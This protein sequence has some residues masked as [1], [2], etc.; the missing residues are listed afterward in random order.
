MPSHRL[1]AP[2][3]VDDPLGRALDVA[4]TGDR[5][6]LYAF[7]ARHSGLPCAPAV[8]ANPTLVLAFASHVVARGK[9][10]DALTREMATLDADRAP[11][12][13]PLEF[14]PMCGVAAVGARAASDVSNAPLFKR[15]M[16]VLEVA[17]EDL[18]FR[19][20]D[21]VPRALVRIGERRGE[22]FVAELAGWMDG[23]FQAAAVLAALTDTTWL[24]TI[25]HHEEIILRLDEA[26]EL[27]R[28]AD[29]ARERYPGYKALVD[30]LGTTPGMIA[31]RFGPP[32]FD[33][34]VAWSTVKEPLLREAIRSS[35]GGSLLG[36]RFAGDIARVR[37][38]LDASAP[39]RR[40]PRT[41]VGSTRGRGRKKQR[42]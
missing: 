38:A 42:R 36:K 2:P 33:R 17:A 40:D 13:T 37:S 35:L 25:R 20:R 18:R 11:G 24:S 23:F 1:P 8:R 32:V 22:A 27:A 10:C 12:G 21:E 5:Q 15:S 4:A 16:E 6:P 31:A 28:G 26:F 9:R 19:V 14:L 7:L 39:L 29:R 34:L 41:D 30:T 3:V